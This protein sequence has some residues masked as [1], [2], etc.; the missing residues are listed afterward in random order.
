MTIAYPIL[1]HLHMGLAMVSIMG[2]VLR[3]VW[4]YR[5]SAVFEHRLTKVLPHIV[6]TL[7]LLA[8]VRLMFILRQYPLVDTW[9]SMKLLLL[10]VYIGLATFALKRARNRTMRLVFF[11]AA[12]LVFSQMVGVALKHSAW[13]WFA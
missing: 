1:M 4:M 11:W 7:L 8:G 6:D 5:G 3:F 13:G 10:L 9:L 2:F 12:V